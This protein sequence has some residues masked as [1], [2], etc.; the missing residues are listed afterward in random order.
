MLKDGSVKEADLPGKPDKVES[1]TTDEAT[2]AGDVLNN[3][4]ADIIG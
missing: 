2:K 4:W 3:N 1:M